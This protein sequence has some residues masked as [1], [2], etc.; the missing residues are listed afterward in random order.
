MCAFG[1]ERVEET[2][3][4]TAGEPLV[5]SRSLRSSFRHAACPARCRSSTCSA[6]GP[7]APSAHEPGNSRTHA[8]SCTVTAPDKH[9]RSRA[10]SHES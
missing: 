10:L 3:M 5:V 1:F 8:S 6:S 2:A 9:I 7:R 4:E